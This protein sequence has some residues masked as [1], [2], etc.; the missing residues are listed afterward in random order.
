LGRSKSPRG[1]FGARSLAKKRKRFRW[2]DKNYKRRILRIKERMDPLEGAPMAEGIVLE[3]I[4]R[5][6]RK[7]NSGVRKC[8]RLQLRKNGKQIGAFLPGD[9]AL[10]AVEEHD[11]VTITKIG[12]AM[13]GPMGDI[14]GI[15]WKV[16]KVNGVSLE[17]ILTGKKERAAR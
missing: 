15:R 4:G 5:E 7:P 10:T 17:A 1:E 6:E 14:A 11:T 16:V 2:S 3:K 9:G 13:G 8:V 12:G